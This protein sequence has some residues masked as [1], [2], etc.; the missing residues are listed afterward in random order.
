MLRLLTMLLAFFLILPAVANP[1]YSTPEATLQSYLSACKNGD[2]EAVENC[3]TASSRKFIAE[4][5][6]ITEGQTAEQLRLSYD[7]LSKLEFSTEKVSD[8]R[9]ILRPKEQSIPPLYL[10]I[11]DPEEGWRID[12]R[13]MRDYMRITDQGFSFRNPKAESI[14]KSRP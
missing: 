11:Q 8:K 12:W 6:A 9:A 5:Q 1:D 14:W 7:K 3:Y 4:N 13:F 10:R 2:K